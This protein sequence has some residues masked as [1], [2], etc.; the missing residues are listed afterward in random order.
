MPVLEEKA[1]KVGFYG[2]RKN[3]WQAHSKTSFIIKSDPE[4]PD[5]HC[6]LLFLTMIVVN[7]HT[8]NIGKEIQNT[9]KAARLSQT[10]LAE[11]SGLSRAI[12]SQT[13]NGKSTVRMDVLEKILLTLNMHLWVTTP[14]SSEHKRVL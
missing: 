12:I 7:I 13:E 8:M 9:R 10:E 14:L 3:T 11:L 6:L 1:P 2:V 5:S 4:K